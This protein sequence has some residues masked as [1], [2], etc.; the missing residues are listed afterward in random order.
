MKGNYAQLVCTISQLLVKTTNIHL[1]SLSSESLCGCYGSR[2]MRMDRNQ[3]RLNRFPVQVHFRSFRL[4]WITV[5]EN[6][7]Q[8]TTSESFSATSESL[9]AIPLVFTVARANFIAYSFIPFIPFIP[10]IYGF[11]VS[12]FYLNFTNEFSNVNEQYTMLYLSE[13]RW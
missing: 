8:S 2:S 4:L 1:F 12:S 10:F 11:Y 3:L 5:H 13:N 9:S 7:S 6:G